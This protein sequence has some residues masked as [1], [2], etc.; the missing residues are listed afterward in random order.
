[1]IF[2]AFL[3]FEYNKEKLREEKYVIQNK[4]I[5]C[6]G[7]INILVGNPKVQVGFI[8]EI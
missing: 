3:T 7:S 2:F 4:Y 1:M 5:N 8:K 6:S